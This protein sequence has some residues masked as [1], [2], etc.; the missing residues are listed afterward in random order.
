M[1]GW[2][3]LVYFGT[4]VIAGL[5]RPLPAASRAAIAL[6]GGA[7]CAAILLVAPNAGGAVRTASP[8]ALILIG[9]YL[10]GLFAVESSVRFE[11]W[12]LSWDQWL[13]GDPATRF[14]AWPRA[15]LA[16]LEI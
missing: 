15:L 12:L 10:S 7:V 4:L 9:Y 3:S 1:F 5:M 11:R 8:L 14:A 16:A 13:I 2:I 6:I